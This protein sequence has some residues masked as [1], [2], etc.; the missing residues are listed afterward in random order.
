VH[1]PPNSAL[2]SN[3]LRI[4]VYSLS[5]LQ[6]SGGQASEGQGGYY[7]SFHRAS[8]GEK[9]DGDDT[10][11]ARKNV[12]A[13]A[14]DVQKIATMMKELEALEGLLQRETDPTTGRAIE[15]KATINKLVTSPDVFQALDRLETTGGLKWGLSREERD[16]IMEAREKVKSS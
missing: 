13:M 3:L 7:A 9:V 15:L 10:E 6:Y 2:N 8:G 5:L 16:M 11:T 4:C 12:L 1:I 14:A